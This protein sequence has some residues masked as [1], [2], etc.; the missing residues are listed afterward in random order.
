VTLAAFMKAYPA[1]PWAEP[2]AKELMSE[3][4][5]MR[6]ANHPYCGHIKLF[7]SRGSRKYKTESARLAKKTAK[8]TVAIVLYH[9]ANRSSSWS[10]EALAAPWHQSSHCEWL[11][12]AVI[13]GAQG[14]NSRVSQLQN[15]IFYLVC[16]YCQRVICVASNVISCAFSRPP[17]CR[18]QSPQRTVGLG[19]IAARR[20]IW[21]ELSWS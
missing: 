2:H 1:K 12:Y 18:R 7:R 8:L 17:H 13:S 9:R 3:L 14:S 10:M 4:A 15:L 20:F 16:L 11:I 19:F 21:F 6:P 5:Q